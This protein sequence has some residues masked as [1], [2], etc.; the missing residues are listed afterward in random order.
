M[1]AKIA[2]YSALLPCP[3]QSN[4]LCYYVIATLLLRCYCA[5]PCQYYVILLPILHYYY[6]ILHSILH[7]T[8]ILLHYC[9]N[10]YYVITAEYYCSNGLITTKYYCSNETITTYYY[11]SNDFIT[12]YYSGLYYVVMNSILRI[13]DWGNL[14]MYPPLALAEWPAENLGQDLAIPDK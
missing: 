9:Y 14:E 11:G 12:T 6:A 2:C 3:F 4:A 13:T 1:L 7:N 8:T 5:I 10:D